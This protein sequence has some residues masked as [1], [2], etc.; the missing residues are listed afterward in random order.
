MGPFVEWKS[1]PAGAS[2]AFWS[3]VLCAEYASLLFART[4]ESML[5]LSRLGGL[6]FIVA[7][8]YWS[9]FVYPPL[10]WLLLAWLAAEL[11]LIVACLSEFEVPALARGAVSEAVPR[12]MMAV[13]GAGRAGRAL[14]VRAAAEAAIGG[15]PRSSGWGAMTG[16]PQQWT[17]FMPLTDRLAPALTLYDAEVPP[18]A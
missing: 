7:Y 4:V 6:A 9:A 10:G 13:D 14:I 1:H 2:V 18:R 15:A 16:W 17:L 8:V 5:L 11:G 3:I 12:A